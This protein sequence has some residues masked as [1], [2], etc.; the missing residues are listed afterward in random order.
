MKF[1]RERTEEM[2]IEL[3]TFQRIRTKIQAVRYEGP[4]MDQE[5]IDTFRNEFHYAYDYQGGKYLITEYRGLKSPHTGDW[6]VFNETGRYLIDV[7]PE[8]LFQGTYQ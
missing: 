4:K 8:A 1:K 7:M 5:L 3:R 2:S 6:L